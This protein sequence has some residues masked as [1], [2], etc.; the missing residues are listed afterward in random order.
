MWCLDHG[1]IIRISFIVKV[2]KI[3]SHYT[4]F[5]AMLQEAI[6]GQSVIMNLTFIW[7]LGWRRYYFS[8]DFLKL[9]SKFQHSQVNFHYCTVWLSPATTWGMVFFLP[10]LRLAVQ[11]PTTRLRLHVNG[12]T[13]FPWAGK[14]LSMFSWCVSSAQ[15]VSSVT[16]SRGFWLRS[17]N[18]RESGRDGEGKGCSFLFFF[19]SG[20]AL[21]EVVGSNSC[22]CFQNP[23]SFETPGI[24]LSMEAQDPHRALRSPRLCLNPAIWATTSW[25]LPPCSWCHRK[26]LVASPP[27]EGGHHIC[28]AYH[29]RLTIKTYIYQTLETTATSC[30]YYFGYHSDIFF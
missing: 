15:H 27:R 6:C 8:H 9:T 2:T 14:L 16:L 23:A 28:G 11:S 12:Y 26:S 21:G 5:I 3:I 20:L 25:S 30:M 10:F 7:E 22:N 1:E 13:L 24:R 29:L 17:I 4:L 19:S 18:R